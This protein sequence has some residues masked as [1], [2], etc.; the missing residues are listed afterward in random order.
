MCIRDSAYSAKKLG[1]KSIIVMPITTPLIK[2]NA[3][4]NFGG[5]VVLFGDNFDEA[6]LE[7]KTIL[8]SEVSSINFK[9]RVSKN[10][11]KRLVE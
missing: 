10:H 4:K 3:V 1:L 11:V 6:L 9:S 7:L 2:I 5:K 8:F